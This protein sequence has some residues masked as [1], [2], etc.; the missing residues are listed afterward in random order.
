M[1]PAGSEQARA[2]RWTSARLRSGNQMVVDG[3]LAAGCRFFSGYPITPASEIYREMT[4]R[5]QARGDVAVGAPDEISALCYAIGASQRG[6]K[7]M[8]ATSGPG[9]ALMI[10]SF[11]YALMTETPLV[12]TV[13]QRLGPSTGGAT[14]GAQGDVL[15]AEFC[16]SGGYTVPV[17]CPSTARECYELTI[18]AFNWSE[19]LRTPVVLLS[20]KEVGMTYE[21]VDDATLPAL[22]ID[23]RAMATRE[24]YRAYGFSDMSDVP[25]FASV[26]GELKVTATG[27]AHNKD[28]WLRKNDRDTLEVL[29][30]LQAKVTAR[31]DAMALVDADVDDDAETVVLSYGVT[32]RAAREAVVRGRALGQRLSFVGVQSL[33]PV[34]V[35][36]LRH[37]LGRARRVIV[38]EENLGGLYRTV[39]AA[40][41]SGVDWVGVNKLGSMIRPGEILE[42]L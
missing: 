40:T 30:H 2:R 15:L 1:S 31:A 32:S 26:G 11:Q 37:A 7:A 28:G 6:F 20:D 3:A 13:V 23:D 17:F 22:P 10:E 18:H 27:S 33:F 9:W 39:L 24:T 29:H 36:R 34:P 25:P 21:V 42:R 16:T 4:A 5:L 12:V 8:T 14:Q 41:I 38:A 19:R 35:A